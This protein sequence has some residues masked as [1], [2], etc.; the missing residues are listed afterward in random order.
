[1]A[2]AAEGGFSGH[3]TVGSRAHGG[4]GPANMSSNMGDMESKLDEYTYSYESEEYDPFTE[5]PQLEPV[6]QELIVVHH[7]N[8][9]K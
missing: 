4:G 3:D 1:M 5:L 7:P 2:V 9:L 6:Y 8:D